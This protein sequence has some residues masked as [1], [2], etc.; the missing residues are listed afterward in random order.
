[1]P[2]AS[3][4]M[5]KNLPYLRRYAWGLSGSQANGDGL[6]R[7]CLETPLQEPDRLTVRDDVRRDGN[8]PGR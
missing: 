8:A 4:E 2:D 5:A 1:M 7:V 6:V 3:Q